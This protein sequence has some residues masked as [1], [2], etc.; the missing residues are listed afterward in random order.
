MFQSLILL[1]EQTPA[2]NEGGPPLFSY[3]PM[4][5]MLV[6]LFILMVVR[7]AQKEEQKRRALVAALKKNDRIVNAGGIIGII[8][9][10]KEKE[11]EVVLKGG[12]H[13]LKSSITRIIAPDE[14]VKDSKD[15]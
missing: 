15:T 7:P 3:L 13:I 5:A 6:V 14:P 1:A 10:I 4:L 2:G 8:D 12:V 9:S 11:D